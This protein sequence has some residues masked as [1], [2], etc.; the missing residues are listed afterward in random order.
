MP[1]AAALPAD[2]AQATAKPSFLIDTSIS[3]SEGKKNS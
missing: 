1:L 2:R 3:S